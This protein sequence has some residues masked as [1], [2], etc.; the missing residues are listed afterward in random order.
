MTRMMPFR[1]LVLLCVIRA[2][3]WSNRCGTAPPPSPPSARAQRPRPRSCEAP[4]VSR[5]GGLASRA[6]RAARRR[7]GA[8][9]ALL[10]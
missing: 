4:L 9:L 3:L 5:A 6:A 1:R 2:V 7:C 8:L 10:V